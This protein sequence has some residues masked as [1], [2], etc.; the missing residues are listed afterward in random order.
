MLNRTDESGHPCFVPEFS[1]KAFNYSLLSIML[2][3]RLS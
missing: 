3:V 1:R 2:A